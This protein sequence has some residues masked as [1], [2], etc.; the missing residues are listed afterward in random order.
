MKQSNSNKKTRV[1]DNISKILKRLNL[2][3]EV[4]LFKSSNKVL[5]KK[6]SRPTKLKREKYIHK[7]RNLDSAGI[8]LTMDQAW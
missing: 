7:Y 5:M 8:K 3:N 6:M 4:A 2:L 1:D